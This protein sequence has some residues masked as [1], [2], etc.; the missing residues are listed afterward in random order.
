MDARRPS[1]APGG[2]SAGRLGRQ[3]ARIV[4]FADS[5]SENAGLAQ[6]AGGRLGR[7][8]DRREAVLG[9]RKPVGRPSWAPGGSSGGRLARQ[10]ARREA[11]LGA[12]RPVGRPFGPLGAQN[13]WFCQQ[14][15]RNAGFAQ[16]HAQP[17]ATNDK[18]GGGGIRPTTNDQPRTVMRNPMRDPMR[19]IDLM[20]L[21]D[22]GASTPLPSTTREH[23]I[24]F[25]S[26]TREPASRLLPLMARTPSFEAQSIL[27]GTIPCSGRRNMKKPAI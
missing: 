7:Q 9:A 8:E 24:Q 25:A 14:F 15:Q 17:Y 20:V 4:G 16:P 18:R 11:V 10:E 26:R 27:C 19:D 2:P 12:R 22:V 1:W 6:A 3:E 23:R 13:R 5:S 21:G